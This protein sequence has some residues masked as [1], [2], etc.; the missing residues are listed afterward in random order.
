VT[1]KALHFLYLYLYGTLTHSSD[2]VER[3]ETKV[4]HEILIREL[5]VKLFFMCQMG[6]VVFTA[7]CDA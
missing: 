3:Q 5:V 1:I 2:C 6:L 4:G 7:R